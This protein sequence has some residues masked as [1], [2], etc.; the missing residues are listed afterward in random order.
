MEKNTVW[1]IVLSVLVMGAFM[2]VQAKF[3]APKVLPA[4]AAEEM[5]AE[6]PANEILKNSET[7]QNAETRVLKNASENESLAEE[8]VTITTDTVKAVFTNRGG[9][10]V[11]YELLKHID[12]DT[13]RG[14]QMA[15]NISENNRALSLLFGDAKSG[16]INDVFAIEKIDEHTVLF[17]K[18]YPGFTLG[19]RYTFKDGEYMFRFDVLF[20]A[21]NDAASILK[22]DIAYTLCTPPQIGPHFD[23]KKNRYES[24]D[25][26][27]YD[28]ETQKRKMLNVGSRQLKNY[29][30]NF[31]WV[32]IAGKY[33]EALVV[34]EK[35]ETM[36]S[37]VFYSSAIEVN[38]YANAQAFLSRKKITANDT[39]DTY[40]V[41]FGPRNEKNLKAYN[42][43]EGNAWNLENIHLTESM[44]SSGWLGWLENILKIIL[45]LLY[46]VVHNWGVSIIVMTVLLKLALF[47][48]TAKQS[49]STQKMQKLQPQMTAIQN[50]YKDTP[51]RMQTELAKLYKDN[52]YS[53]MSGCLPMIFQ[54][55]IIFAM[56]NLFNNYFEFR[57]ASFIPG[58]I[59][60]LSAGDSVYTFKKNIPI[61][62]AFLGNSVRILPVIYL[63]SQLFYGRITMN[64]GTAAAAG[65]GQMK[66]MMYGMP[67]IFFFIF[68]NAPAGLLL[69]WTVSNFIQMLQQ[70][71]INKFVK[72]KA[73]KA[74]ARTRK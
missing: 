69:Y 15:D 65:A 22:N 60:D 11:S 73:L 45:E 20:H 13:S 24:R 23:P 43:K 55:L 33:F 5:Q 47:P 66:F 4:K 41:Y 36:S 32:G 74:A 58:W 21:E 6:K 35:T 62:S 51:Q 59:P 16:V 50:K 9:D 61:V 26:L 67:L 53:P 49:M 34:P 39:S 19:K 57:G 70:L 56:F 1:A 30:K 12:T 37:N 71:F 48:I 52:D 29:D 28:S 54:F 68:Y 17:T 44:K 46:K 18:K 64:G 72:P 3:F 14:V 42:T 31:S 27:S 63:L 40:Y 7:V 25:F 38:N 10:I 2:F 8:R